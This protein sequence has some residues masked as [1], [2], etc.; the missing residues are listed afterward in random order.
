MSTL[1]AY[2]NWWM[3]V[4]C[5]L[6]GAKRERARKLICWNVER[7]EL[8]ANILRSTFHQIYRIPYTECVKNTINIICITKGATLNYRRLWRERR[9]FFH[10]FFIEKCLTLHNQW[11]LMLYNSSFILFCKKMYFELGFLSL[12]LEIILR[13]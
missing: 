4:L 11:L 10:F 2:L 7:Y 9:Y 6:C 5:L 13:W 3:S 8:G 12:S 1:C